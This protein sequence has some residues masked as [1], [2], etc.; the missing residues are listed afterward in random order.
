MA[1]LKK[2]SLSSGKFKNFRPISKLG[3]LSK[4]VEKCVA[5]QLIYFLDANGLNV[6]YQSAFRKLH[7]TETVL[8]R[9]HNDIAIALDQTL[10][11]FSLFAHDQEPIT[12]ATTKLCNQLLQEKKNTKKQ[13]VR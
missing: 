12:P 7:S 9:V 2:Q 13:S 10:L 3:F 5:K 4:A 11:I 1:L 8:I 6:L